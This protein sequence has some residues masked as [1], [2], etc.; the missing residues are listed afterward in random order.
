MKKL[1][2]HIYEEVNY[3]EEVNNFCSRAL[4]EIK[5][6]FIQANKFFYLMRKF[7]KI[8]QKLRS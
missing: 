5:I 3:Y 1:I 7:Q 6:I 4:I 8:H 2:T